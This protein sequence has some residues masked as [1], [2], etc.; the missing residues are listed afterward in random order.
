MLVGPPI[1]RMV[2]DASTHLMVVDYTDK[3]LVVDEIGQVLSSF[4]V[5]AQELRL[6]HQNCFVLHGPMVSMISL[7]KQSKLPGAPFFFLFFSLCFWVVFVSS[8]CSCYFQ[9]G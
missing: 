6:A 8:L 3:I 9:D 2:H 4:S 1:A 7:E 5:H